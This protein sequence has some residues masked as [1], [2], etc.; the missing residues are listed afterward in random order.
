MCGE[1]QHTNLP[2]LGY[3]LVLGSSPAKLI[4]CLALLLNMSLQLRCLPAAL[5]LHVFCHLLDLALKVAH[6]QHKFL[7]MKLC[8]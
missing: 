7:G 3:G 5:Y 8:T 6:L 2:K 4:P 1:K